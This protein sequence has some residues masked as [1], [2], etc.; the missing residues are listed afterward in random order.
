MSPTA[1]IDWA[2]GGAEFENLRASSQRLCQRCHKFA[3]QDQVDMMR[4]ASG[5]PTIGMVGRFE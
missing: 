1:L 4:L 2:V 3:V 5:Q